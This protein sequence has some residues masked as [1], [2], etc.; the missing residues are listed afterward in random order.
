[1]ANNDKPQAGVKFSD[2]WYF[3]FKELADRYSCSESLIR[4]RVTLNRMDPKYALGQP[5]WKDDPAIFA[6]KPKGPAKGVDPNIPGRKLI[7][8]YGE[9]FMLV[10]QQTAAIKELYQMVI[11]LQTKVGEGNTLL[12]NLIDVNTTPSKLS[13]LRQ[14]SLQDG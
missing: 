3:T 6:K 11:E 9:M 1:M 5:V 4:K 12:L 13:P 7:G 10:Q 2:G 8:N 14:A